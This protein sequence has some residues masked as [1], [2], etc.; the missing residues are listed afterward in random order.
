MR[1]LIH[2]YHGD[3]KGKTTAAVGLAVRALGAGKK[4][5]FL[6]CMKGS[7]TSEITVLQKLSGIQILRNTEDC[8]FYKNMTEEQKQRMRSMHD[9]SM[10]H[11][12]ELIRR[13]ECDLLILDE[14]T[15]PFAWELIDKE[16][17]LKLLK[18]KPE[19]LEIVMT[20]RNPQP[21]LFECA[22][23]ITEMC[24]RKHP[25]ERGIAARKGIEF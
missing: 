4:I 16:P 11:A 9:D 24:C 12:L 17:V 6:Q 7:D 2:L 19:E 23:Y 14:I 18:H 1:G 22:D 5:V 3:G 20:G 10:R 25:Y 15:Y 8:G 13:E 21:E